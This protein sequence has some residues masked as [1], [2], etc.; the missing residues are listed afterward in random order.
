MRL[1]EGLALAGLAVLG[2]LAPAE[3]A[4]T[5]EADAAY[6][7]S[8]YSVLSRDWFGRFVRDPAARPEADE[9]RIDDSWKICLPKDA[10]PL[11]RRMARDLGDFLAGPMGTRVPEAV[12]DRSEAGPG[13][14]VLLDAGGGD[15][16]PESCTLTVAKDRVTVAGRDPAG[17]R[18][19]VVGLVDRMGFRRAPIL[20]VGAQ[21]RSPRLAVRL[22]VRPRLGGTREAVF[23]GYNAVFASGG[24]LY[25]FSSSGAL[26]E[27]AARRKPAL[28]AGLA[29]QVQ[30]ASEYGLRTYVFLETRKKFPKDDPLFA[31]RPEVRGALTWQADGEYTLCTEHPLV[32]QYLQESVAGL[33]RAA[34]GLSGVAF[35]VGGEGFYHCFMR[36]FGVPKGRTNCARCDKRGAETVVANLCNGMAEAARAVRPDA[37]VIAWPYSAAH[38]W[39]ADADQAQF[40][41]RLKPGVS[42][43][44][45]VEKDEFVEKPGGVRKHLWD[46][47]IDLVDLGPRARA[48]R[49]ACQRA[50]VPFYLK[51][52][53]E[54]T[55]EAPRLPHVPCLDRWLERS[56][57]IAGSGARGTYIASGFRTLYGTSA[58]EIAKYAW[59]SPAPKAEDVLTSLAARLAGPEAGPRLRR[60]WRHVSDAI[61]FSPELPPYFVGPYYL[62]P[63][64]PMVADPK[65]P[66]PAVFH[67][68]FLFLAEATDAEGQKLRPAYLT[69]PR[70]DPVVFGRMYR[71]MEERL[72]KAAEEVR[73]AEPLV[74]PAHRVLFRAEV[75]SILWFYATART[76]ANFYESCRLRDRLHALADRPG[77]STL[78]EAKGLMARWT[79]VLKDESLNATE[80]L[81]LAEADMRLDFRYS[82]DHVFSPTADM[83]RAK[84]KLLDEEIRRYLPALWAR[85]RA[86]LKK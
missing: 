13:S 30:E 9:A 81:P 63:A 66:L 8:P 80:A 82:H 57:A 61:P 45:E 83:V 16:A 38:V 26:P 55:F 24:S 20:R 17:L 39:S 85:C 21:T 86:G 69:A 52:E 2:S 62:G 46:Y 54:V 33:F 51:T 53:P 12:L 79:E 36:P 14:I 15:A 1:R 31:R 44:S 10:S 43:L 6:R 78:E 7:A 65:A 48:Q 71:D 22:G 76:H 11:A 77:P 73:A 35:I 29:R 49:A 64:H 37:E 27:L 23:L 40:I 72:R 18:D 32:R 67:G 19:G 68:K 28:L 4:Q 34:P 5:P 58:A 41:A 50:G 60:A 74:P 84:I 47:S 56:E 59:W 70:G 42:I 75:S 3:A 25:A